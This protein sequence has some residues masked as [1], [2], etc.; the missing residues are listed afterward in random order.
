[1]THDTFLL[2]SNVHAVTRYAEEY[3]DEVDYLV[4]VA[5]VVSGKLSYEAHEK[6]K[7]EE[8]AKWKEE[9]IIE[10]VGKDGDVKK[11]HWFQMEERLPHDLLPKVQRLRMSTLLVGGQTFVRN[12]KKPTRDI[13]I[14]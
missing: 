5:P 12:Y 14:L 9:G 11:Q 7:P 2:P 8:F 10:R 13:P 3:P 6:Y 4:P 1:M